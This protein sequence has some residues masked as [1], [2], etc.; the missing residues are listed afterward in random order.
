MVADLSKPV[1]G[2]VPKY[3]MIIADMPCSGSGTWGRTPEEMHFFSAQKLAEYSALQKKSIA[4]TAPALLPGSPYIYITCSVYKE[5]NEDAIEFMVEN[6]GFE[7][8]RMET[9][10]GFHHRADTMFVAWLNLPT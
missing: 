7:L 8:N 4:N 9:I 6:F 5:E 1:K 3:D 10:K 2:M